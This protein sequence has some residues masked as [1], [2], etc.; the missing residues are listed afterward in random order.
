MSVYE[1]LNLG[2]PLFSPAL[3]ALFKLEIDVNNFIKSY[4]CALN[5]CTLHGASGDQISQI[6]SYIPPPSA[7][8]DLIHPLYLVSYP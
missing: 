1:E 4:C 7:A 2:P 3:K 8:E 6:M 5:F